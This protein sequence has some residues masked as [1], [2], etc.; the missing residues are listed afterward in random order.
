MVIEGKVYQGRD[1]SAGE[2]FINPHKVMSSYLG[3]FSFLSQWPIDLGVVKRAKE[4]ISLGK[5]TSLIK[6]ISSTG[7]L[8]L[9]DIIAEAKKKDKLSREI[10]KEAA[11][12]LGIKLSFLVNFLNPD[13][14][15][16]GGGFRDA[17]DF[18][19]QDIARALKEFSF[20]EARKNLKI[21][22]SSLGK[23]AAPLGV[24]HS[25]F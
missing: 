9:E 21:V 23:R 12:C 6:K 7:D 24:A 18:F 3:D 8:R 5:E 2:L 14:I 13:A 19:L 15:I 11:F 16:V 4:L 1:G 22:F 17:G 10:L 25:F 20:N